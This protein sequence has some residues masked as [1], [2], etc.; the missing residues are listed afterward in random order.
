MSDELLDKLAE[1]FNQLLVMGFDQNEIRSILQMEF[2]YGLTDNEYKKVVALARSIQSNYNYDQGHV[3]QEYHHTVQRMSYVQKVLL[4]AFQQMIKNYNAAME[5]RIEHD[6]D[7][8]T[9]EVHPVVAVRALDL[10]TMGEKIMKI[11][12]DRLSA[13]LNYP[14]AVQAAK[15]ALPEATKQHKTLEQVASQFVDGY[16][17][18]IE[19]A[20]YDYAD[21]EAA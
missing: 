2:S 10:A 12:N 6:P 7:P 5:G 18:D 11:D 16:E 3:N 13:L 21:H 15:A 9:G 14:K 19:D 4:S 1:R 8:E 17:D 20:E